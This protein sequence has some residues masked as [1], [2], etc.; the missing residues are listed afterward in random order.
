MA[1]PLAAT[2]AMAAASAGRTH[3][4]Q[5]DGAI[6]GLGARCLA[7]LLDSIVLL[8]FGMV[9][10]AVAL[11]I[12]FFA[13]DQGEVTPSDGSIWVALW[14]GMASV[15]AWLLLNLWLARRRAQSVGQYVVGL[16]VVR[17]DGGVV[18]AH[19][20]LVRVF[21][22]NPVT[23]HPFLALPWAAL[24]FMAVSLAESAL[25]LIFAAAVV[26]LCAVAPFIALVATASDRSRR[27]LHDRIAGTVVVRLG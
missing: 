15:P 26:V 27:A 17:E 20:H 10:A 8:A 25:L 9:F 11:L 12:I 3:S 1:K 21:A 4:P 13:S 22:L 14:V 2:P 16:Q 23:F 24:A 5:L 6:A 18:G 19:G 7:F